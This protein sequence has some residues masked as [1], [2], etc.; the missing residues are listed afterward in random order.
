MEGR[1][2]G[3]EPSLSAVKGLTVKRS[4]SQHKYRPT[5]LLLVFWWAQSSNI[6]PWMFQVLWK[7][8]DV[9]SN[10]MMYRDI[11][12]KTFVSWPSYTERAK[13]NQGNSEAG[14]ACY[15][16]QP[17]QNLMRP[18]QDQQGAD[19]SVQDQPWSQ[20]CAFKHSPKTK[21]PKSAKLPLFPSGSRMQCRPDNCAGL[22]LNLQFPQGCHLLVKS[23]VTKRAKNTHRKML[24]GSLCVCT[25]PKGMCG[26][27]AIPWPQ[28]IVSQLQALLLL[29]K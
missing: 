21:L 29:P 25:N 24:C 26:K 7:I 2:S 11:S 19:N 12:P 3:K 8:L 16:A 18:L 6:T 9:I 23:E 13:S 27:F 4:V 22:E 20:F 14:L 5:H 28:S 17:I 15:F 10:A 1:I